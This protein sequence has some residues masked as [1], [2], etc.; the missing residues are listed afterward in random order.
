MLDK[1]VCLCRRE[2]GIMTI[3]IFC[4]GKENFIF[5]EGDGVKTITKNGILFSKIEVRG[6]GGVLDGLFI[7]GI[8]KA[9][10]IRGL[11]CRRKDRRTILYEDYGQEKREKTYLFP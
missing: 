7:D 5:Y 3:K 9:M 1:G 2:N 10:G 6:E 11:I 8:R 4:Q